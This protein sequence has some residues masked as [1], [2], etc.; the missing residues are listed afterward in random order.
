MR[1]IVRRL[2]L[3][4]IVVLPASASVVAQTALGVATPSGITFHAPPPAPAPVTPPAPPPVT[5]HGPWPVTHHGALP[6]APSGDLFLAGP[7]TYAPR[8]NRRPPVRV[9]YP[10]V[11][12]SLPYFPVSG[13]P[14]A[15]TGEAPELL[16]GDGYD[17]R[18]PLDAA[19]TSMR[20]SEAVD[21]AASQLL[22]SI[23]VPATPKTLY[24]IPRCYAG[25]RMPDASVLRDG[26][27]LADVIVIQP[28]R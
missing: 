8:F 13:Y 27:R 4:V 11:V 3:V 1:S 23:V 19:T 20:P 17:V 15:S 26:C 25:D 16:E 18:T 9:R 12:P 5:S 21:P 28:D 14:W 24:V 6:H 7:H 22:A 10:Y 2:I